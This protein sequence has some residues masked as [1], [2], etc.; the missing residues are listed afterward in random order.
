MQKWGIREHLNDHK[1]LLEDIIRN[2]KI[3][4]FQDNRFSPLVTSEYL[5]TS[6]ELI[7]FSAEGPLSHKDAPIL[8]E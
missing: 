8:S 6:V 1:P 7:L 4:A 2:A 5:R 3:A